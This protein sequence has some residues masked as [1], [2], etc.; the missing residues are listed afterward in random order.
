MAMHPAAP[1]SVPMH[2]KT[3]GKRKRRRA[4]ARPAHYI[5]MMTLAVVAAPALLRAA[6]VA[7]LGALAS[8]GRASAPRVGAATAPGAALTAVAGFG[9]AL[10]GFGNAL[11]RLPAAE[12]RRSQSP[13]P[14]DVEM[15]A[16]RDGG[17]Q[18]PL[19]HPVCF[20]NA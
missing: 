3:K 11:A 18:E 20:T 6:A 15:G 1:T 13:Q 7:T 8:P 4:A 12:A 14:A 17:G 5:G 10:A 9:R 19:S 16:S 2:K